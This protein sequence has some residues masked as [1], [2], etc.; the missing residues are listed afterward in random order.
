MRAFPS[1]TPTLQPFHEIPRVQVSC[2]RLLTCY[3]AR[4]YSRSTMLLEFLTVCW[5]STF[6]DPTAAGLL[7]NTLKAH[8]CW[9]TD[10]ATNHRYPFAGEEIMHFMCEQMKSICHALKKSNCVCLVFQWDL[11]STITISFVTGVWE[12]LIWLCGVHHSEIGSTKIP[13]YGFGP[14]CRR[15]WWLPDGL[16]MTKRQVFFSLF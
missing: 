5:I 7:G 2:S 12:M 8:G 6:W 15:R 9:T 16:E 1:C 3:R 10:C 14:R 11:Q 13:N 4:F